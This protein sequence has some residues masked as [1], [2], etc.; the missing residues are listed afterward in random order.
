M[1][2]QRKE[3]RTAIDEEG[4][5]GERISGERRMGRQRKGAADG[6]R[7]GR[8]ESR[9]YHRW[10]CADTSALFPLMADRG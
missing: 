5:S 2:R 4:P 8:V 1:G 9:R 10:L 3:Q 7:R 6:H